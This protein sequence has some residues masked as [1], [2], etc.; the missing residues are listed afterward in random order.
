MLLNPN[1]NSHIGFFVFGFVFFFFFFYVYQ[2]HEWKLAFV[3]QVRLLLHIR[4]P[5]TLLTKPSVLL[6]Y[7]SM[8]NFFLYCCHQ[9]C[10]CVHG[11]RGTFVLKI[12]FTRSELGGFSFIL[13][14][15]WW[16]KARD[17]FLLWQVKE[18]KKQIQILLEIF[19]WESAGKYQ[20]LFAVRAIPYH[21]RVNSYGTR[22]AFLQLYR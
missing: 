1:H 12:A 6:G 9:G 20:I 21:H 14:C 7:L 19:L 3:I 10:V 13:F 22:F 4:W 11:R 15:W 16:R 17:I 18:K 8:L 5:L 2:A